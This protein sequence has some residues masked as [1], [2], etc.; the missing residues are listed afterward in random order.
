[1]I[2]NICYRQYN[3]LRLSFCIYI[4]LLIGFAF[5]FVDGPAALDL[6]RSILNQIE[7]LL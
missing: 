2:L 6:D 3:R 5:E 4:F 1:M 7:I